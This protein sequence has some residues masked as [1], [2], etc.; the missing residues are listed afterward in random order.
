MGVSIDGLYVRYP[1]MTAGSSEPQAV[2]KKAISSKK[3]V[4]FNFIFLTT[5]SEGIGNAAL[6]AHFNAPH[7]KLKLKI[8][9]SKVGSGNLTRHWGL[10]L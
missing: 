4:V 7:P 5:M 6:S 2:R 9:I 8:P 1:W 10:G 3:R